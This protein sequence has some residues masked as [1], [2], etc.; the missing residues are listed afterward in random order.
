MITQREILRCEVA[1]MHLATKIIHNLKVFTLSCVVVSEGL[2]EIDSG[3][4][5]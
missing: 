3:M 1:R 5:K 4:E 2:T